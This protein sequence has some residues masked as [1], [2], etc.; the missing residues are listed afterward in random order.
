MSIKF[1][2][3]CMRGLPLIL[4][5]VL[6]G[7]GADS[8]S[9]GQQSQSDSTSEPAQTSRSELSAPFDGFV[10]PVP[11]YDQGYVSANVPIV[12]DDGVTL[13]AD[14]YSPALPDGSKAPGT[15]PVI[16]IQ[17]CYDK[18]KIGPSVEY[19]RYGYVT[20]VVDSR[21]TGSSEGRF[22]ILDKREKQDAFR[23]MLGNLRR[24]PDLSLRKLLILA[25]LFG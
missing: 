21:G 2:P 16:V 10:A 18:A 5:F 20:V 17:H 23:A 14:V 9:N 7:C 12:I 22:N 4:L 8:K 3:F 25:K 11:E 13:R 24:S 1:V 6:A 15:F 19:W